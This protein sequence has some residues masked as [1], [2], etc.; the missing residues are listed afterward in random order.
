MVTNAFCSMVTRPDIH[1]VP[2]EEKMEDLLQMVN[3]VRSV[4]IY[5]KKRMSPPE[6]RNFPKRNVP[7]HYC[8]TF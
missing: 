1:P 8:K 6:S 3:I 2:H 5:R 7:A 4:W